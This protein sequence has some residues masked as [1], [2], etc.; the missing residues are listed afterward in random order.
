MA[1]GRWQDWR[2][3]F[4]PPPGGFKVQQVQQIQKRPCLQEVS[5]FLKVQQKCN[6]KCNKVQQGWLMVLELMVDGQ[7]DG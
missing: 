2:R 5:E 3:M 4:L 7:P 1:D 6:T